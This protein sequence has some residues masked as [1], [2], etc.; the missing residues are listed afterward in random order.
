MAERKI[1]EF[2]GTYPISGLEDALGPMV[3]WVDDPA[4][5]NPRL[6][7]YLNDGERT[8]GLLLESGLVVWSERAKAHQMLIRGIG[9]DPLNIRARFD[10]VHDDPFHEIQIDGLTDA[11]VKTITFFVL[12]HQPDPSIVLGIR[13]FD[14]INKRLP[15]DY[16]ERGNL[17]PSGIYHGMVGGFNNGSTAL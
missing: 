10:T 11:A 7:Q 3:Y 1:G 8:I 15:H 12:K 5:F 17:R 9:E 14:P 13:R 16:L 4:G 6:A 2:V